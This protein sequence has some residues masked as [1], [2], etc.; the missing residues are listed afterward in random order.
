M[1]YA[2]VPVLVLASP[3]LVQGESVKWY[4][5]CKSTEDRLTEQEPLE[6]SSDVAG[7]NDIAS[8]DISI[9][10]SAVYQTMLGFGGALTQSSA[11]VYK[12]LPVDLQEQLMGAYYGPDGI[13]YTTGRMPIHSCD[14][15]VDVYTFDDESGDKEL[16]QFDTAVEYD[17][18]LSLPMIHD[19]LKVT[20]VYDKDPSSF[21][22]V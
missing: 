7:E 6:F 21:L 14:F 3:F 2:I 15:S 11:T 20:F 9:D 17:Q 10:T 5:T 16:E 18:K 4:Q 1:I 19:A 13:G 8:F 22:I 12:E